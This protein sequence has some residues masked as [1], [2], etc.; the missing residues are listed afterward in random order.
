MHS[1]AAL[2][3]IQPLLQL[4]LGNAERLVGSANAVVSLPGS[5]HI[6][7]HLAVLALEEI[8][9]SSLIFQEHLDPKP[10]PRDPDS[11][12]RS[13][14]EWIE[15]HERKIF[16]A[17]WLPIF[18]ANPDWRT[19]PDCLNL[20]KR[21]HELRL[22][23]LYFDPAE[24]T[25]QADVSAEEAKQVIGMAEARLNME[26]FTKLRELDEDEKA[27]MQW[28]FVASRDPEIKTWIYSEASMKKQSEMRDQR[29]GWIKWLREHVE[30]AQRE[31]MELAKQEMARVRPEGE[32]QFD[33]K[34]RFTIRLKTWSHSIRSN[35]LTAFNNS[36]D[37]I[38]LSKGADPTELIVKFTM[39]KSLS[40]QQLWPAGMQSC[41]IFVTSLNIATSGFFWWYLPTFTSRFH[42]SIRDLESGRG[43]EVDRVPQLKITWPHQALKEDLLMKNLAI[44]FSFVARARNRE[45][46]AFHRYFKGLALMA[47]NDIFVQFEPN[48]VIEF[49]E[50]LAIG[51]E[52]YGDWSGDPAIF[53]DSVKRA[54]SHVTDSDQLIGIIAEGRALVEQIKTQKLQRPVTLEDVAKAK[55]AFD[56]YIVLKAVTYVRNEM[57]K[58]QR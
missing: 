33:D 5:S 20:A 51:M 46:D 40:I 3:D 49:S 8:G 28:F 42:E 12:R 34:W 23:V 32:E 44:V 25:A 7:Y 30:K 6:A 39:P 16:W 53:D 21:I 57:E 14:L 43:I 37:K 50:S 55:V 31:A 35:Q 11:E 22:R 47:K 38:E 52:A 18:D 29:R 24:P 1:M 4:C 10:L 26:K 36:V 41:M 19:I 9:K 27:E 45:L 58:A 56:S 2:E 54:F 48:I 17:I 13:P 15:D